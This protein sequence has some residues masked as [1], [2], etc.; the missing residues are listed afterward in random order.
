[1]ELKHYGYEIQFTS[2]R[3]VK[4]A[5]WNKTGGRC[6]YCGSAINPFSRYGFTSDH[7]I[8]ISLG[9]EDSID[10]LVPCCKKCNSSKG[11][12]SLE[13]FRATMAKPGEVRFSHEQV[14][15][16]K[17]IGTELPKNDYRFYFEEAGLE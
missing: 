3:E 6:W 11:I 7:L 8:P 14:E 1:M 17:S 5:V 16:L 13:E 4:E 9:G 15:F 10:N 2:R 12:K